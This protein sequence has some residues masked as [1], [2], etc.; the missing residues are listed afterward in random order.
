MIE[1]G[2]KYAWSLNLK[3]IVTVI[4]IQDGRVWV[5]FPDESRILPLKDFERDFVEVIDP[6]IIYVVA[7]CIAW[8]KEHEFMYVPNR[9]YTQKEAE[10]HYGDRL[11]KW[12]WGEVLG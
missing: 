3:R 11:V 1:A 7:Q 12:P 9:L 10:E 6:V 4:A 5:D 2:K 8:D